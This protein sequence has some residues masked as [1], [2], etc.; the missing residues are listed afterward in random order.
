MMGATP[1]KDGMSAPSKD[2]ADTNAT[3]AST[4]SPDVG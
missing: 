2:H 1:P 4:I 3:T